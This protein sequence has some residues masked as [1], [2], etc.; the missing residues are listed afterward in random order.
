[1]T[2]KK[3]ERGVNGN[4]KPNSERTPTERKELAEKAGKASG[5]ARRER[6]QWK[7]ILETL[8]DMPLRDETLDSLE[9]IRN[10]A[11]LKGKNL[12]AEQVMLI[13]T[14]NKAMKGDPWS[15]QFIRDTIGQKP[16]DKR[17]VEASIELSADS[18]KLSDIKK[19]IDENPEL[20]ES[21][22]AQPE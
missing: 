6:K 14:V 1:M 17:Q 16:V 7:D 5:E 11:D 10:L 19:V 22:F 21:I 13:Q 4:L 12:T 2:V 15:Q 3:K 20:F 8:I 9:G 18:K